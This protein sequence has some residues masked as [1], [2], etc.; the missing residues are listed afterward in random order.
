[1]K[2]I[3]LLANSTSYVLTEHFHTKE[4]Q[5]ENKQ[6]K[7]NMTTY[8]NQPD[9]QKKKSITKLTVILKILLNFFMKWLAASSKY[10]LQ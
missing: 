3:F 5:R 10:L 4:K 1:M 8:N 6:K 9:L 7:I 2:Y